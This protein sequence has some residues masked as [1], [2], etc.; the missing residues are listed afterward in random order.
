MLK[1]AIIQREIPHYRMAFFERLSQ[2]G[3]ESGLDITV[4]S[5]LKY[6]E[7]SP[8]TFQSRIIPMVLLAGK[9][10]GPYWLAGLRQE[11]KESDIVV[12]PHELRCLTVPYL[13]LQRHW[14][15]KTWIWWG[16]GYDVQ[17]KSQSN[18]LLSFERA[19]KVF[20]GKRGDGYIAYTSSG[21]KYWRQ[22]GVAANRIF[23]YFNTLDVEGLR[24]AADSVPKET[25]NQVHHQLNLAGKQ[26]LLFS[27][28]LYSKKQVDFLLK[29]VSILQRSYPDVALLILGD[30]AERVKLES[31]SHALN[32]QDVH[33]L[34]EQ[35]DPARASV[36]FQLAD[37]LVLPGLVGLAIVH[38]FAHGVPLITTDY[39]FHSPEIEYLSKE[40][41][42]MTTCDVQAYADGIQKVLADKASLEAMRCAA[43]HEGDQL[44]L[45]KS[46]GR[47]IR[48]IVKLSEKN[49][50]NVR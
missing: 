41:G 18:L 30:G 32:L 36:Y 22:Q 34:G 23:T 6:K 38:G 31:L 15:A 10:K 2:Q 14:L 5:G 17:A 3:K 12:M 40:N 45:H 27:G 39:R 9:A 49:A 20:M 48:A 47:F 43:T 16:H 13:W 21:V 46:V 4:Y 28:R 11:I 44:A 1:V 25:L 37:L 7:G 50:K 33:F 26:V 35:N 29:A 24:K 42:L 19:L 8:P